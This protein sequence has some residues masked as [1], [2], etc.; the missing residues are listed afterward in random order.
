MSVEHIEFVVEE[1][2]MEAFLSGLLP[3]LLG[4]MSFSIHP[5]QCKDELLG[6]LP[7]RLR[8]YANWLPESHRILVVVDR[9]DDDCKQLKQHL[10]EITLQAGLWTRSSPKDGRFTVVNRIAI[11]ELEA[12]YFGDWEA[13]RA[14]YPRVSAMVPNQSRYRDPDGVVGGTWEAF[15]R[16]LKQT[17]YFKTGLRK[18][19]AARAISPHIDLARNKSRSFAA[20]RDVVLEMITR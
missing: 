12:W 18:I 2:S 11:E 7:S 1:P 9:D 13:V 20:F 5:F 19:E 15:E 8:G 16:V 4:E 17:G 14:A 3:R 10:E 6:R